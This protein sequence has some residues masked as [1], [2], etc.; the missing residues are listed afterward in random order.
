MPSSWRDRS[1]SRDEADVVIVGIAARG[2]A[3]AA[4]RAGLRAI[5]LDLFGDDDTREL[6]VEA[7]PLRR[8]AGFAIDPED[9]FEQLAIHA[10]DLPVVLGTGFEHMPEVVDRLAARFR[11]VGNGRA[12]LAALKEPEAFSRLLTT[13]SVPHPRIFAERAPAGIATLEKRSGGSGGWHVRPAAETRGAGWYLQERVAGRTV[14]ALFLGNGHGA[15]LLAFSEQ[16]CAPADDA[17][18]RYGGAVG[19]IR[20]FPAVERAVADALDRITGATG[21]VGL[22]SAD[23]VVDPGGERW[24][25]IE[26]NPRPGASLDVFDRPPLPPLLDLHFDACAGTLPEL[27]LLAPGPGVAAR[28]AGILYA[29]AAVEMRLDALPG[30]VADRPP[31]GTRIEAG[32]PVCTVLA[33]GQDIHQ[34]RET[35]A[36]RLD[37]FWR[38]LIRAARKAAE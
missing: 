19:P 7:I 32:E 11:L 17:P 13:L 4:R 20:L 22:A 30:W 5:V 37:Q 16:W 9:L 27:A 35:L 38:E 23:I 8:L 15:R 10:P 25:L 26:I 18:F 6:A 12:V 14:S 1:R 33:E 31:P 36:L 28:A 3:A 34:A 29:P 21:L 2:L 24:S